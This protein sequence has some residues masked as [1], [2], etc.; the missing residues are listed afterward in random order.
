MVAI[1]QA[2]ACYCWLRGSCGLLFPVAAVR[3]GGMVACCA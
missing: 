3:A 2:S 1:Q